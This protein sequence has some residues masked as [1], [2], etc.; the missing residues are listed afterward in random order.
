MW[1]LD[2]GK[3]AFCHLSFSLFTWIGSTNTAKLMSVPRLGNCKISRLLFANDLALLSSTKS[4][5]Q[6]ALNSFADA[7]NT[8]RMKISTA[9]TEVL[10][11]S[12]NP[13]QCLLQV[14][15]A[16]L[17]LVEKF[18]YLGVAFTSDG[19]QDE[20]LDTR[21]G[22]ASAVMRALHYSVVMKRELSKK[23]KLS[24]FKAVFVPILTYGHE[25]WVMTKR[26]RSQVQASEM[27]FLRRIEGVTL[28]NKVRSSKIRKSL[29]IEPLLLRTERSQLRWFGHVS[30]MPQERLPKQALH[31]KA[32]GRRPVGRPRTRWTDYIEDLG[33]NRLGLRPSEMMEVMEDHEVWRLNLE[34]LPPQ[35]SWKSRQ[36]R[37]KKKK[38]RWSLIN[39]EKK[40]SM[41]PIIVKVSIFENKLK[42]DLTR[43]FDLLTIVKVNCGQTFKFCQWLN[44]W[45]CRNFENWQNSII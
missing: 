10:H 31:A 7:C 13:D 6:R 12:R 33:W 20:E 27:R 14:N 5:V 44:T 34:L 45:T 9:K 11:L 18:K 24:I 17:K 40:S 37:K 19:R 15:G 38:K 39:S 25:P 28:F 4:G 3:G 21:I 8:A 23:A 1:M 32:N 22:K 41:I 42:I 16:T 2:S 36:W 43:F 35:P 26:V 29:K 30:R